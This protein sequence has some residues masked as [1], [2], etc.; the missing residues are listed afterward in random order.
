MDS[1]NFSTLQAAADWRRQGHA[2]AL[3]TV[4]ETWG[5]SP[6]PVGAMLCLHEDG[7]VMGS[8]S[9]GCV[10]DDLIERLRR[11]GMPAA[12]TTVTYG[13]TRE[14]A[15]RFGLPCGGT[16]RL[17]VEPLTDA[18][19]VHEVLDAIAG[20]QLV[21]RTIDLNTGAHT[22]APA[23]NNDLCGL[24]S[25]WFR[26]LFGPRWRLLLIGAGQTSSIAAEIAKALD[27]HVIVCDPRDEFYRGW[28]VSS[29][30]LLTIMP[31]DA[32]VHIEPDCRTAI[33]ALT[34]DPKLDDMALLEALKSP[35]FYVGALGS[36]ENQKNRRERLALFDLATCEINRLYGPVGLRIGSR[37]PAEIAVSIMA[38]II[39]VRNQVTTAVA[40]GASACIS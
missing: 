20:H 17:I 6:R 1:E 24:E 36:R 2:V 27:F 32:V 25:G 10:E 29:T 4:A 9:G 12:L 37:T 33:V 16:L 26:C 31:D 18:L 13:V 34:H 11:D 21:M 3:V 39:S 14:E 28:S 35:A 19:W 23:R 8:V 22:L 7:R 30:D 15:A 40:I 5:S 38:E